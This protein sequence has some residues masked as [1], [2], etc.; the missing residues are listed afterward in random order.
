MGEVIFSRLNTSAALQG[1]LPVFYPVQSLV[2]AS[3][4]V[5]DPA[6]RFLA[7]LE[8]RSGFDPRAFLSL[9]TAAGVRTEPHFP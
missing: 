2:R 1:V 6:P 5:G 8:S 9:L 4:L 3:L 7:D